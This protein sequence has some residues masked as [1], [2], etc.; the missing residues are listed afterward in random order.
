V[1]AANALVLTV[2]EGEDGAG[3]LDGGAL[4]VLATTPDTARRLAQAAVAARLSVT[5]RS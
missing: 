5:V 2:P 1:V 4:V 3:P